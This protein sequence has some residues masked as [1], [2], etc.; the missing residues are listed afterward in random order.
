MLKNWLVDCSTGHDFTVNDTETYV[1]DSSN[2]VVN[3]FEQKA[4]HIVNS[5]VYAIYIRCIKT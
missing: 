1:F 2:F 5:G 3:F 4:P